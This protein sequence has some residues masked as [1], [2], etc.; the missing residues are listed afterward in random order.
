ME[1]RAGL[2]DV[3][4]RDEREGSLKGIG[5]SIGYGVPWIKRH[6]KERSWSG[7]TPWTSRGGDQDS[8][9]DVD[10]YRKAFHK[11]VFTCFVYTKLGL[12]V[13]GRDERTFRE[14]LRQLP[15]GGGWRLQLVF[16]LKGP[17]RC[18]PS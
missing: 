4:E 15:E 14:V 13:L 16:I 8:G 3:L 6:G 10:L 5:S 18:F 17:D 7:V 1:G 12:Y 2:E 9:R 11:W